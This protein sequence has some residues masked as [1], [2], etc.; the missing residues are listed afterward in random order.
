MK[1]LFALL[2]LAML[3]VSGCATI[4]APMGRERVWF[5]QRGVLLQVTHTCTDHGR[6]YQAGVGLV[7]NIHGA[8]PQEI[9]LGPAIWGDR[10]IRA[11][12]Q[13]LNAAGKVVKVYVESFSIDQYS[14][15][16]QTWLISDGGGGGNPSRHARCGR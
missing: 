10:E 4:G 9:P 11:T 3:V 2:V 5:L 8:E 1:K 15:M 13:S 7:A 14:T 6:L 16:A 12:L